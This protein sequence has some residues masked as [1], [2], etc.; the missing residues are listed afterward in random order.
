MEWLYVLNIIVLA[1]LALDNRKLKIKLMATL[2]E[3][4]AKVTELQTALDAEQEQIKQA[5]DALTATIEQLRADVAGGGTEAERQQVVD[6]IQSVVDDLKG[7][8][9]DEPPVE[10]EPE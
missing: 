4:Q 5:I 9:P 1:L 6:Q 3:V 2:A 7:T 10:P 8:I